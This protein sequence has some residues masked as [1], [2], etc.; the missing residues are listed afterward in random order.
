MRK[1]ITLLILSFFISA[2]LYGGPVDAEKAREIAASFW[3]NNTTLRTSGELQLIPEAGMARA[4]SRNTATANDVQYYIFSTT[5]KRGFVIIS[6]DDRLAPI[7]GYSDNCNIDEMPP[8]LAEWL[9]EYSSYVDEVRAGTAEPQLHS[10]TTTE[11]TAIAPMLKTSW[12]QSAPYNNFCPKIGTQTPP[13]GCT[14]TAMAQDM[15]FH[16][17]PASPKRAISW[18]NNITGKTETIDITK[19]VYDWDNMLPHYRNGYT[20]AQA[21]AV[22]Q[23]M[24]DV[25]KAIQSNYDL[26]GTG[27][28]EVSA[29][30]GLVNVFDYSPEIKVIKRN[31]Y[32][33]DEFISIVR[34]NLEAR[35]PIVHTGHG[36]SYEA[37][38]AFVCDGIDKDN[39]L[40]IDWGWDGAYNGYFDIGSM[41]PGGSGI[42]GGQDR[43]NVGQAMIVNIRPRQADEADRN[44]DPTIYTFEV[45]N[46]AQNDAIVESHT[47]NFYA[48]FAKF[49]ALA[50]FLNWSHSTIDMQFG[51]S[52]TSTDGT[53]NRTTIYEDPITIEKDNAIGYQIEFNVN[54]TNATSKDYLQEGTYYIEVVYK[55]GDGE[56]E[57]MRGENNRLVLEVGKSSATLSKAQPDIEVSG[58]E[59][60]TTPTYPNDNMSFDVAF[61]N[62]NTSNA[63]VIV[64]PII[65]RLS[66]NSVVSSDTL[67]NKGE[68]INVFDN[69]DF[70]VTYSLGSAIKNAGDYNVSFAYDLRNSYNNHETSVDKN[71]L[72]SISGNSGTF[73]IQALSDEAMPTITA[74]TANNTLFGNSLYISARLMNNSGASAYT[75]TVGIFAEKDGK[76]T[77]IIKNDVKELRA[78]SSTVISYD[79]NS[80]IFSI[81]TGTYE[82][83]ICELVN[84]EWVKLP[85]SGSCYF[86]IQEPTKLLLYT[87]N[88]ININNGQGVIQGDSIDVIANVTCKYG[89]FDGY[90]RINVLQGLTMVLR[91]NYIP[92]SI[93]NG[94][95]L[96]INLRSMCGATAPLGEWK[97]KVMYYD[98]KKRELGSLIINNITFP[99]NGVFYVHDATGIET[100]GESLASVTAGN[101]AISVENVAPNTVIGVYTL[102]GRQIYRGTDTTVATERGIYLVTIEESGKDAVTIKAFVK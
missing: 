61:R 57:K 34:E 16:E 1:T 27:S 54:N 71:S 44:G 43:Y 18:N 46:A 3:N 89:D 79:S 7:V 12:N 13:T 50:H 29:A 23:L 38:H 11:G 67:Y 37:G 96:N 14:A 17:W 85:H 41:A 78:G 62:K 92:A 4:A 72:K 75:G 19:N 94:E 81:E 33:Y 80:Y 6:G 53:F 24:V 91:S 99:D 87:N 51:L 2:T 83:Y 47:V 60:R 100:T 45:I 76:R 93:K 59:F 98:N 21:D 84:D 74:I 65:N 68:I 86:A 35:Q 49:K 64:V 39:L 25:G 30:R 63:T 88:R 90:M 40:H 10:T 15:K 101:G 73:T 82:A 58:F 56:P 32:T 22:A 9:S 8:A 20:Q 26:S 36:Q 48:G 69:T 95:T 97:V 31:E 5:E 102:D 70:L 55:S 28:N 66:N 42:G 77:L 52:I